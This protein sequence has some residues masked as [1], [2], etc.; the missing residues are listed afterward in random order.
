MIGSAVNRRVALAVAAVVAVLAGMTI[1][2]SAA[3]AGA[4]STSGSTITYAG[5][6]NV[7]A[8]TV[9]DPS[10]TSYTFT[11]PSGISESSTSCTDGGT[12]I[13]CTGTDWTQVI[14]NM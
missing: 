3:S 10:T 2:A 11:E 1:F 4:I 14:M 9:D 8:V 6:G 5:D 12:V 13:T 7:N